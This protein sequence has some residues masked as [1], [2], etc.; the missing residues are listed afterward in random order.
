MCFFQIM[1]P[2]LPIYDLSIDGE[3]ASASDGPKPW[4]TDEQKRLEQA[5]KTFPAGPDRWDK[6]AGAIPSR[7]KKEC[8]KRYKVSHMKTANIQV[9]KFLSTQSER[10]IVGARY[11]G[12]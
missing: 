7:T 3:S 8:M 11:T 10:V 5:L 6:I 4:T 12:Q 1:L 2:C 9:L